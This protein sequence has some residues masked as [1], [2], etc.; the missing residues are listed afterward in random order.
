M[1]ENVQ[2]PFF[3]DEWKS[4]RGWYVKAE[5]PSADDE[6]LD[7]KG[8]YIVVSGIGLKKHAQEHADRLNACVK[9]WLERQQNV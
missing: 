2:G 8:Y 1:T 7:V 5:E 9:L 6:I 4:D 3:V